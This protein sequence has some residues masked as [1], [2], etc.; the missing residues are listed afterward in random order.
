MGV[1]ETVREREGLWY[2]FITGAFFS[3]WD[4][5]LLKDKRK[6][7]RMFLLQLSS[8][9]IY[10]QLLNWLCGLKSKSL[11][12]L[13]E[14]W[15]KVQMVIPG[16]QKKLYIH[17]RSNQWMTLSLIHRHPESQELFSR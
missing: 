1:C 2:I 12:D 9:M 16:L 11:T 6:Q 8:C 14:V 7:E 5:H 15:D 3:T 4:M 17:C 10:L 13:G